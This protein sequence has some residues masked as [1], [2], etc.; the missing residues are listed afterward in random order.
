MSDTHDTVTCVLTQQAV[1]T[2]ARDP[3]G[4]SLQSVVGG[5]VFLDEYHFELAV[6][7]GNGNIR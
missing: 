6:Q 2:F 1:D 3:R 7:V 4:R 5:I